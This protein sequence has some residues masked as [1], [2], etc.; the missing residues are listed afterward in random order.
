MYNF[1][2]KTL[3]DNNILHTIFFTSF[4]LKIQH[5]TIY[6]MSIRTIGAITL[7]NMTQM[8]STLGTCHFRSH[9]TMTCIFHLINCAVVYGRSEWWPAGARVKLFVTAVQFRATF[10][11]WVNTTSFFIQQRRREGSFSAFGFQNLPL[12]ISEL[13]FFGGGYTS[14]KKVWCLNRA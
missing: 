8:T 13:W 10:H 2:W 14:K 1:K 4:W 11:A 9:H 5:H 7:K 6:A 3:F 12:G